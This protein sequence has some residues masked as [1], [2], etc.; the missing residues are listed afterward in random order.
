MIKKNVLLVYTKEGVDPEE[1][2]NLVKYIL[3]RKEVHMVHRI[4]LEEEKK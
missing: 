3:K 1:L 4:F 2:D